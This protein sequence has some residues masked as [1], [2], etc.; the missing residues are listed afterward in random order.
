MTDQTVKIFLYSI[1]TGKHDFTCTYSI[2]HKKIDSLA[3][4]IFGMDV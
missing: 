2:K 4:E 1:L 3:I